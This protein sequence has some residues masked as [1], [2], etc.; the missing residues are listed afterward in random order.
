MLLSPASCVG[1]C[2]ARVSSNSQAILEILVSTYTSWDTAEIN[3]KKYITCPDIHLMNRLLLLLFN[4]RILPLQC[5][6]ICGHAFHH[7][8]VKS[9]M[10]FTSAG[11]DRS[12]TQLC[13]VIG[14]QTLVPIWFCI[15]GK[16]AKETVSLEENR[17]KWELMTL[18]NPG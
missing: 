13:N 3:S 6:D 8:T 18:Y 9:C 14:S 11:I 15:P 7:H 12:W 16:R 5:I 10:V 2:W 17:T 4:P 1:G